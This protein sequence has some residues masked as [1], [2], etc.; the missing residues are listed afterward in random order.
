VEGVSRTYSRKGRNVRALNNISLSVL[1]GEFMTIVGPSG[2]G[3]S[4][5]LQIMGGFDRPSTG[6]VATAAGPVT[7]PS[8]DI[9][10]VFQRPTLFPWWT[11]EKNVSWALRC[12][13]IKRREALRRSRELLELVGLR[14]FETAFP[15]ELSGGMQQRAALART[16]SLEPSVLLMDEPFSALDAQTRELMQEELIRIRQVA[17]TTIVFVTH[18][19]REA[20][21]LGDRIVALSGSPGEIALELTPDLPRPR[22]R[23]VMRSQ[24]FLDAYEAV[25]ACIRDQARRASASTRAGMRQGDEGRTT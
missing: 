1:T 10:M 9:G 15:N 19:I 5:L 3:K 4:T 11:V 20:V 13:G 23:E 21:F 18:D 16:L 2:C 6:T 7:G 22:T 17:G 8:R 24:E 14:G 25:W 12:G